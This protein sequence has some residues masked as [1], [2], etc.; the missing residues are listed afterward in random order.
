[1][2]SKTDVYAMK[3]SLKTKIIILSAVTL[4]IISSGPVLAV[5]ALIIFNLENIYLLSIIALTGS[6]IAGALAYKHS[7][8][9]LL[10]ALIAIGLNVVTRG[11][12]IFD[13]ILNRL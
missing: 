10:Y 13:M 4:A 6:A 2:A 5:F 1:M 7:E 9:Y 8:T 3:P 12:G 11:S